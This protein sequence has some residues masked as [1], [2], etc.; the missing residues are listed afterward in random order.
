MDWI[1]VIQVFEIWLLFLANF[2]NVHTLTY[3]SVMVFVSDINLIPECMHTV[4][5]INNTQDHTTLSERFAH[6]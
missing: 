1:I 6:I 3:L 2:I 4:R 5:I